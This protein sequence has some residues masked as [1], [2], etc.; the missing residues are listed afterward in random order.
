MLVISRLTTTIGIRFVP[1][2]MSMFIILQSDGVWRDLI[3]F[4]FTS[5]WLQ[6]LVLKGALGEAD[7]KSEHKFDTKIVLFC[8]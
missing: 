1:Q 4:I 8:I 7:N 2:S 5:T 6:W 3:D